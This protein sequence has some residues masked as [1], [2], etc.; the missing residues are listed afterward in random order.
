M[1]GPLTGSRAGTTQT[2]RLMT[3]GR[4]TGASSNRTIEPVAD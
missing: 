1:I 2:S 3:P 4:S